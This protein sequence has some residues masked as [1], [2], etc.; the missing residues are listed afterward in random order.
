MTEK[1]LYDKAVD[2]YH[3]NGKELEAIQAFRNLLE[4]YPNNLKGWTHL[5]T[6]QN[7]ITDFDGAINSINQAIE[8]EPENSWTIQQKC[9]IL[10]LILK[11]PSEGQMYFDEK[12]REAHEIKSF[13]SRLDLRKNLDESLEK[14]LQL[15]KE[16]EKIFYRYSWKLALNKSKL[17]EFENAILILS[18]IK[19]KIPSTFNAKKKEKETKI[20]EIGITNNLMA[21]KKYEEVIVRLK[22]MLGKVDDKY[23]LGLQLADVYNKI[24]DSL[25]EE[26]ILI[27]ILSFNEQKLKEKPELAYLIRKFEILKKLERPNQMNEIFEDFKLI[28]H[29]NDYTINRKNEIREIVK[30]Y[31]RKFK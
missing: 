2:Y 12:T 17:N 21:L 16:N 27:Q 8:I 10:S 9:T 11:F 14:V 7:A 29:T 5:A 1:E 13:D 18:N 23:S 3:Q 19:D 31:Q 15:E 6:M 24:K 26:K 28:K 30:N 25:N 4:K 20:I 22:E